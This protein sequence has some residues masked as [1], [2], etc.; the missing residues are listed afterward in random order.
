[1]RILHKS[2]INTNNNNNNHETKFVRKR[3][4]NKCCKPANTSL[5]RRAQG[6]EGRCKRY[7]FCIVKKGG[8]HKVQELLIH[9]MLAFF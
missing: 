3:H 8:L 1:M 4:T 9:K 5:E 7:I 6:N 2:P